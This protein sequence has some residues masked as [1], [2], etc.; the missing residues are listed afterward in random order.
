MKLSVRKVRHC[1]AVLKGFLDA[2]KG[3]KLGLVVLG[4]RTLGNAWWLRY[5]ER[6]RVFFG[7][8]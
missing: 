8:A 2:S 3:P 4:A 6:L 7:G 1:R 5:Q